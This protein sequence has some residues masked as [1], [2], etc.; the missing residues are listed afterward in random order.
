MLLRTGIL[1]TKMSHL[2]LVAPA[3]VHDNRVAGK[4]ISGQAS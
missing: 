1:N 2:K 3:L 4:K